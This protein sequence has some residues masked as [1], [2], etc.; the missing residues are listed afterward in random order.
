MIGVNNFKEDGLYSDASKWTTN[1]FEGRS[2]EIA[3]F[4]AEKICW[5]EVLGFKSDSP[6][7]MDSILPYFI[8]GPPLYKESFNSSC[9]AISS[10]LNSTQYGFPEIHLPIIDVRDLAHMHIMMIMHK[11]FSKHGR[12]LV[13]TESLWFSEIIKFLKEN[14]VEIGVNKRIKT[15]VLG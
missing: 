7:Q 8:I 12:Y 9:G 6:T 10:I 14:R 2:N 5:N 1:K 3:K 15:R 4:N 13:G 11:Q